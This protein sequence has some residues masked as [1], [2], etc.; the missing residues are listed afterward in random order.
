MLRL[1]P[2]AADIIAIILL[3]TI[4]TVLHSNALLDVGECR[5]ISG[6]CFRTQTK[7]IVKVAGRV[8]SG[9]P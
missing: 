9:N 7:V 5:T 6:A 2:R 8:L 1:W 3:S 4:A